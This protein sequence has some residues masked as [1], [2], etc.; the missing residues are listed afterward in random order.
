[1]VLDVMLRD[2]A[3]NCPWV[4]AHPD[5]ILKMGTKKMIHRTKHL[6]W[7]TDTHLYG[8]LTPS[9]RNSRRDCERQARVSSSKTVAME[10]KGSGRSSRFLAEPESRTLFAYCMRGAEVSPKR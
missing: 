6:G 10:G 5:T 9:A 3:S 2:V 1:M 4:S 8:R 7:G